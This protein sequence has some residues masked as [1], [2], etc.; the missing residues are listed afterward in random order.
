MA[1][2][3]MAMQRV[4]KKIV[5]TPSYSTPNDATSCRQRL[6]E[7]QKKLLH[8]ICCL[9]FKFFFAKYLEKNQNLNYQIVCKP[10]NAVLRKTQ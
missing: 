1:S 10:R 5:N 4:K 3:D 7:R 6:F 9:L 2:K 8:H